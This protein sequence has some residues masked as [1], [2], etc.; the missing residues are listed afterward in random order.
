MST[1][2]INFFVSL[3]VSL[4]SPVEAYNS[5][6]ASISFNG[7]ASDVTAIINVSLIIDDVYNETNSSGYNATDYLFTKKLADGDHTWSYQAC[8]IHTCLNTTARN[9]T[10]D[11]TPPIVNNAENITDLA[12]YSLPVNST[13]NYTATDTHIDSCYYNTTEDAGQ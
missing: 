2:R 6:S 11:T 13:W 10:V 9:L 8:D 5:S 4:T 3:T 1:F 7:T 12:T